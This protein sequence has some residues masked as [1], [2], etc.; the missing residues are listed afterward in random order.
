MPGPKD[1]IETADETFDTAAAL[2]DI[3]SDL[4]GQ[5]GGDNLDDNAEAETAAVEG[6]SAE[7][8][9]A[10]EV[11]TPTV[12]QPESENSEAVQA[13][14]APSTWTKDAIEEWA[15]IP[16]RAQQEILKRE[17]DMF[18][19]IQQ[20]KEKAELGSRYDTVVEPFRLPLQQA[21][22]DPVEL[23]QNFAGNHYLLTYGTPQQKVEIAANLLHHYG[24]PIDAVAPALG[25]RAPITPE[26]R[27]TQL[28]LNQLRAQLRER[29]Q[30]SEGQ[31][32][33]QVM[34]DINSFAADP[35]NIH[36]EAVASHMAKLIQSGVAE[37]LK[38]AYDQAVWAN[39]STRQLEIDRQTAERTA[40]AEAERKA[41][42]ETAKG[43]MAT[44]VKTSTKARDGT[45]PVGSMDDTLEET[46][47]R[48]SARG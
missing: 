27:Q 26:M 44:D 3:S 35:A 43:R 22:V 25:N 4:F 1:P 24:I 20:Y 8:P 9:A 37:T 17:Q 18:A 40:Q 6:K 34:T 47:A 13:V 30:Q 14:G 46:F 33:E 28:E 45:I 7:T 23:F 15:K 2:E 31:L 38:D 21:G 48:I 29:D 19:G 16:P 10:P 12:E 41:R 32:R 11:E 39:P 36:F 42:V 5:E